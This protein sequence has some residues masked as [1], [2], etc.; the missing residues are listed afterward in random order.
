MK[1]KEEKILKAVQHQLVRLIAEK[2]SGRVEIT[3]ELNMSQGFIGAADIRSNCRDNI[4][5]PK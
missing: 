2:K 4:F 1:E 5:A 3:L